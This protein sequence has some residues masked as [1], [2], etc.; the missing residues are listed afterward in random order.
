MTSVVPACAAA[1]HVASVADAAHDDGTIRAVG[2]GWTGAWRALDA[3][4]A[5]VFVMLPIGTRATRAALACAL[6]V[7]VAGGLLY[8]LGR[9]LLAACAYG[10][11]IGPI[12]AALASMTATIGATW[13][14]EAAS[15]GGSVLGALLVLA[16]PAVLL[17]DGALRASRLPLLAALLGAAVTYEP[18][19]G[20][21]ALVS[22]TVLAI[23]T[24]R[25]TRETFRAMTLRTKLASLA[26][27][28]LGVLPFA[29]GLFRA[30]ASRAL[31]LGVSPLAS[32]A[33]ER[34]ASW[35]TTPLGFVD[36]EIGSPLVALASGGAV[37]AF[38]APRAR[39][40]AIALVTLAILGLVSIR[41][42]APGGP[43]RFGAPTLVAVGAILLLSA[44]AM[45]AVVRFVARARI[46]F[47]KA[48]AAMIVVIELTFPVHFAD[49]AFARCFERA[50]GQA[51]VWDDVAWGTLPAGSVLMVSDAR[52]M[53]RI[54]ASRAAGIL[55]GDLA[56]I[57]TYDLDGPVARREIAHEPK[58][59]PFWRD[60]AITTLPEEFSL[61]S[62]AAARPLSL[63]Y[64][65]RWE[66][67][68]ARH[69]V[70]VGLVARFETEP[71]GASD[72]RRALDGFT[73]N[74]DRLARATINERDLEL[75]QLTAVLLRA[76]AIALAATG[77]K[78]LVARGIDDLHAFAPDDPVGAVIAARAALKKGAVDVKGLVP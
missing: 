52:V 5:S 68:L 19:V 43:T 72:R 32:W 16:L 30:Q 3:V 28:V 6:L 78:D 27:F 76:R 39:P 35:P 18:L 10:P 37:L 56:V 66:H 64:D 49:D 73:S 13:Q 2:F 60:M 70:P 47:A 51:S 40:P 57:P 7:G 23:T 55:R 67:S 53:R 20:M 26:A 21:C 77:D 24:W 46:P 4:F 9:K 22:S 36:A 54:L 62:L 61:S 34:G 65:A 33:G 44:V 59:A 42:G 69:L 29:L 45:Q 71:R 25:S 31:A 48:S 50:R 11:R 12:L 41:F 15:P 38:V 17:A 14:L 63:V 58:L 1:A 75:I 74:R 8:W